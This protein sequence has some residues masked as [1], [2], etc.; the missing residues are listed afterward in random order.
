MRLA[1]LVDIPTC[2]LTR[3]LFGSKDNRGGWTRVNNSFATVTGNKLVAQSND[4]FYAQNIG[5]GCGVNSPSLFVSG[6]SI[7]YSTTRIDFT[8]TTTVMQCPRFNGV[9]APS[10]TASSYLDSQGGHVA[11]SNAVCSWGDGVW[12]SGSGNISTSGLKNYW[13]IETTGISSNFSL[14]S[15]CSNSSDNGYYYAQIYVK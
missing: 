3:F 4:T 11:V 7:L 12:T 5:V 6:L 8:R 9:T 14:A 15:S 1:E 13:R 2:K 10:A